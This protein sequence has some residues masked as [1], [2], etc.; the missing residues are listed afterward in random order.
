[1]LAAT[2]LS[3]VCWRLLTCPVYVGGCW[4]Q[5]QLPADA[6]ERR[7][8]V[9]FKALKWVLH[10]TYRLFNRWAPAD[11]GGMK[12]LCCLRCCTPPWLPSRRCLSHLT[13]CAGRVIGI[14][15]SNC[16]LPGGS[17]AVLEQ[18]TR[19]SWLRASG[20]CCRYGEPR[21]CFSGSDQQFAKLSR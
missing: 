12:D 14:R 16:G 7:K 20:A 4:L 5:D 10:I 1:M 21:L 11:P 17:L 3:S 2:D 8:W 9:W 19:C 15:N 13:A 18:V 6:D